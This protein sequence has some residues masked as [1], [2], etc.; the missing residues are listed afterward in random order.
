MK[1]KVLLTLTL[2]VI[3][4]ASALAQEKDK[5]FAFEISGGPSFPTNEFVEGIRM[6]FGFEGTFK[7]RFM[8]H[9]GIYGGWGGNWLS[10]ELLTQKTIWIMRKPD[11]F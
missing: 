7:Y 10:T 2:S 5:R 9:T 3:L 4:S 8:P 6:G 11:T 1:T